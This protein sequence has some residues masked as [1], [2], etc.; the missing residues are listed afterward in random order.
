MA[1][2]IQIKG[3]GIC[4]NGILNDSI[5]ANDFRRR[6]PFSVTGYRSEVD[7]CCI[8][9]SG[10]FDPSEFTRGWKNGDIMLSKGW[11]N[12]FFDGEDKSKAYGNMMIIGTIDSKGINILKESPVMVRF[13][14]KELKENEDEIQ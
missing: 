2:R 13:E 8:A 12:F 3:N 1:T 7:Y 9:A 14:I 4:I 5:A 11:L 10:I 6:L